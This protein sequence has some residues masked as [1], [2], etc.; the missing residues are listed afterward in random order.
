MLLLY[1]II[2]LFIN[3]LIYIE[4][5]YSLWVCPKESAPFLIPVVFSADPS[6]LLPPFLDLEMWTNVTYRIKQVRSCQNQHS[7]QN[8]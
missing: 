4:S 2:C 3:L 6:F 1:N 5:I 8:Q 7:Q